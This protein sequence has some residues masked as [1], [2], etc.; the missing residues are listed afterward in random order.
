MAAGGLPTWLRVALGG[1]EVLVI[2]KYMRDAEEIQRG[3]IEDLR[4]LGI[5]EAVD[6]KAANGGRR[7]RFLSGGR[8]TYISSQ[9]ANDRVRGMQVELLIGGEFLRPFE[10]AYV[11]KRPVIS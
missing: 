10:R 2:G 6:I 9:G 7:L 3:H 4:T 8:V 1:G 11:M 5:L